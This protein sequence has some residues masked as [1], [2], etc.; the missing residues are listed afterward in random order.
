MKSKHIFVLIAMCGLA[1]ASIGVTVNCG[2]V[3]Y[4]PVAEDLGVGRGNVA[5]MV[6]ITSIMASIIAMGIPKLLTEK[7][8]KPIIIIAV[9]LLAGAT[10]AI[11]LCGNLTLIYILS[12]V[13]GVGDG[14]I[15]FVLITMIVNYW[16]YAKRG[17]F[18]SVVMAFSGV[19]GVILSPIFSNII[20]ASGWRT[21]FV[22]AAAA[23]VLCCLPAVILPFSIRPESAGL[24]PYGYDEYMAA[25]KEGLTMVI[26]DSSA[27]FNYFNPKF[28][29]ALIICI[30]ISIVAAVPQHLPGY[31]VSVG[32][33]ASF[34]AMMLS[35]S[36][37]CNIGSKLL[38]G[39][40][41]DRIGAY[42]TVYVM[43]FL[44]IAGIFLLLFLPNS[45]GLYAGAGL[46]AFAFSIAAVGMAMLSGY[47]FGMELYA[48]AYP[49]ISFVGGIANALAATF[50]G[51]LYDMTGTYTVNFWLAL[52]CQIVLLLSLMAAVAIRRKERHTG[53][54]GE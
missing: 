24:K 28:L 33:S 13:R 51:T 43:A 15:N 52:A 35:V 41:N 53:I 9:A 8:L 10:Y 16:F 36:M 7:T 1:A 47:L 12:A 26:N 45:F 39:V 2:G 3:F 19:P 48:S 40:L 25:R 18:T 21:G 6:T 46:L 30:C 23:T 29:L 20:S 42:K 4:A 22:W 54:E 50:V 44:N 14:M 11:S 32:K 31:A 49:V 5:M 37:A 17:V 34:G 27:R 38:F